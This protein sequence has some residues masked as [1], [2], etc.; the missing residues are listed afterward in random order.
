MVTVYSGDAQKQGYQA[1]AQD[2]PLVPSQGTSPCGGG[3]F[4]STQ[5]G[6]GVGEPHKGRSRSVLI[7]LYP[8]LLVQC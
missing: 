8:Q 6:G 3:G 5:P 1:H 7:M 4:P 2:D